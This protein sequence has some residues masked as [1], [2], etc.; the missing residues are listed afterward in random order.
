MTALTC[1]SL[2][3]RESLGRKACKNNTEISLVPANNLPRMRY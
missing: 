1:S 2:G 3:V